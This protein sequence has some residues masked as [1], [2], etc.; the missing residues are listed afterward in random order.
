[1]RGLYL[2]L[3]HIHIENSE[4]LPKSQPDKP[5]HFVARTLKIFGAFTQRFFGTC[6]GITGTA[7]DMIPTNSCVGT[8]A[9]LSWKKGLSVAGWREGDVGRQ[10][11]DMP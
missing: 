8:F 2:I 1:M 11:S 10:N 3:R 7:A 9:K 5:E 4:F 6:Q